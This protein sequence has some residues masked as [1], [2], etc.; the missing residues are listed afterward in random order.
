MLFRT[1]VMERSH[2]V[3]LCGERARTAPTSSRA[4][5]LAVLDQSD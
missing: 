2:G 3:M 1:V 4:F 5:L